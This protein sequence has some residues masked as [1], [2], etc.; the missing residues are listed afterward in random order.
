MKQ[1]ITVGVTFALALMLLAPGI[2]KLFSYSE[3][4]AYVS[5]F[6][7]FPQIATNLV[8]SIEVVLGLA[9]L[10][11]QHR[12]PAAKIAFVVMCGYTLFQILVL[13]LMP[14]SSA[15]HCYKGT[16]FEVFD[17]TAMTRISRNA[18]MLL[19]CWYLIWTGKR[20]NFT[21]DGGIHRPVSD[22]KTENSQEV[23]N[24]QGLMVDFT[25]ARQRLPSTM[26]REEPKRGQ[27]S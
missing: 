26:I 9:L 8:V 1:T 15:C 25:T 21:E 11:S 16:R 5:R 19:M 6:V 7:T 12:L 18:A 13:L 20:G 24:H 10:S 22:K 14:T 27:F 17:A 3:F 2:G 23:R 4:T